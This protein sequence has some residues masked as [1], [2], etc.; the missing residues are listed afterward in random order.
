MNKVNGVPSSFLTPSRT[1]HIE[2]PGS[3]PGILS[4]MEKG[5]DTPVEFK[6]DEVMDLR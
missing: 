2:L 5:N 3:M 1:S 4:P 6:T